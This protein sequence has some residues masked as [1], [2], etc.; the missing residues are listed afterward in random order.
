MFATAPQYA[1]R[2]I[3]G[4]LPRGMPTGQPGVC[5]HCRTEHAFR[6]HYLQR[7]DKLWGEFLLDQNHS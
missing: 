2:M 1:I 4:V 6:G 3:L 7:C 5:L